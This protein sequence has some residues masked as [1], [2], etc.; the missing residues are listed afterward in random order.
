LQV[1]VLDGEIKRNIAVIPKQ[2]AF[3]RIKMIDG[4]REQFFDRSL[5]KKF[6]HGVGR[7]VGGA[8]GIE[9]NVNDGVFDR[10]FVESKF[11]SQQRD[12]FDFGDY[13]INVSQWN[14]G[15]RFAP[16]H[17]HISHIDL[18]VKWDSVNTADFRM[19]SGDALD[20]GYNSPAHQGLEGFGGDVPKSGEQAD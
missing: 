16:M 12:D 14:I 19:A 15:G 11:S 17:R 20:L 4:K 10:D 7:N 5:I 1:A 9:G 3:A 6:R 13:A 2:F 8:I 18:Q